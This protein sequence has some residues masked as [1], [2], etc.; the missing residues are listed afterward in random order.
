MR[1]GLALARCETVRTEPPTY[2]GAES[3]RALAEI[4]RI[5]GSG[6][7]LGTFIVLGTVVTMAT[8]GP[9]ENAATIATRG[10]D[11][12]P[13][14]R[15]LLAVPVITYS[16][17]LTVVDLLLVSHE[18]QM[19]PDERAFWQRMHDRTAQLQQGAVSR[20]RGAERGTQ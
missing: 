7:L 6:Q 13:Q 16:R 17:V 4:D 19:N 3:R 2:L 14:A 18:N 11:L 15:A 1:S 12:T 5:T 8:A 9:D 20:S 10:P